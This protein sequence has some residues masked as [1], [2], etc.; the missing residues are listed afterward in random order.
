MNTSMYNDNKKYTI[1]KIYNFK[2]FEINRKKE[3]YS[4][5]F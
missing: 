1:N 4:K 5:I 2:L 3:K